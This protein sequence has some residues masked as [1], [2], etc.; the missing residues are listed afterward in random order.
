MEQLRDKIT[1][2]LQHPNDFFE[3]IGLLSQLITNRML[4]RNLSKKESKYSREK[5]GYELRKQLRHL[6]SITTT[7]Q[8][9]QTDPGQTVHTTAEGDQEEPPVDPAGGEKIEGKE[10]NQPETEIG[11]GIQLPSPDGN[12][13]PP[14]DP[15]LSKTADELQITLGKMYNKKGILINSLRSIPEA[16][17]D[18]RKAIIDQIT[19]I[20]EAMKGMEDSLRHFKEKG[21]LP[22]PEPVKEIH[23]LPVGP[24]IP[25]DPYLMQRMLLNTR[26][27]ISKLKKKIKEGADPATLADLEKELAEKTWIA[28]EIL[29]RQNGTG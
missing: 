27:T 29:R 13:L 6:P 8:I 28:N 17:N 7:T 11:E 23:S 5:L 12:N 24:N 9:D 4:I 25:D 2:W 10:V 20:R 15:N 21:T 22:P 1:G 3:G 14:A 18:G 26:S 19:S 16:D